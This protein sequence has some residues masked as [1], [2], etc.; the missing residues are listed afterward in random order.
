[1][2]SEVVWLEGNEQVKPREIEDQEEKIWII[3]NYMKKRMKVSRGDKPARLI[4]R[5]L[6]GFAS[7]C[8]SI[9]Q[10]HQ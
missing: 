2:V 4:L 3:V 1:M 5:M 9:C 7:D 8:D 6:F 10:T